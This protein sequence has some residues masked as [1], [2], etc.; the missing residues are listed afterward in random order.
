LQLPP[1]PT[2][3]DLLDLLGS[4]PLDAYFYLLA[5][6]DETNKHYEKALLMYGYK[7]TP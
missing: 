3:V 6:T 7:V 4:E 1:P 2:S 5:Q